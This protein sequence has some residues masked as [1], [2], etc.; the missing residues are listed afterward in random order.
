MPLENE[1]LGPE[2]PDGQGL[3]EHQIESGNRAI[4][5]LLTD[6]GVAGHVDLVITWRDGAYEVWAARGMVRFQRLRGAAGPTFRIVER[7]GENP[8]ERQD[9]AAVATCADELAAASASGHPAADPNRAF[10]EPSALTYPWAYE[11][12]AQ[13]FDSPFAPDL[14]VSPRW[15]PNV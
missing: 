12:I 11:R 6:P 8:I 7:I 4:L 13:L 3:D 1:S 2:R 14:V 9:H 5:A 10:I 15:R